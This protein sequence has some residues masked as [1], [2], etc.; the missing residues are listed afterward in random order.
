ML[1]RMYVHCT[2]SYPDK[3]AVKHV[4]GNSEGNLHMELMLGIIITSKDDIEN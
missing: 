3:P 2:N 4:L 1:F